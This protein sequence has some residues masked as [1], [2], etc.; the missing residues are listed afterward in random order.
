[1]KTL[2][3]QTKV[4]LT[5]PKTIYSSIRENINSII[6]YKGA[7]KDGFRLDVADI[8]KREIVIAVPKSKSMPQ[9]EQINKAIVYGSDNGVTVKGLVVK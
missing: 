8:I 3:T 6:D 5:D 2:D 1:M 4:K 7:G 9:W